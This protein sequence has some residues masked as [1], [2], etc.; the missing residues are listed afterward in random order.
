[1]RIL[2]IDYGTKRVGIAVSDESEFLASP[3]ETM[4][5]SKSLDADLARLK[6]LIDEE[7]IALVVVGLP[8]NMDG[9]HGPMAEEAEA[10]ASKLQD[11]SG[12]QVEFYDERLTSAEA[13]R[14][15]IEADVSRS[16]RKDLRDSL[17]ATLILQ[18]F[19]D[20]RRYSDE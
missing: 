9:T 15:L 20:R 1:M 7:G 19:L 2:G 12:L 11:V 5:R 17:A 4:L 8:I 13:E 10:F 14:V 16:K 3:R 6:T 18:G